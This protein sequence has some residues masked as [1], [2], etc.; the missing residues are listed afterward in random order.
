MPAPGSAGRSPA[1]GASA[2]HP[3]GSG[4]S[5]SPAHEAARERRTDDTAAVAGWRILLLPAVTG[6]LIAATWLNFSLFPLAWVAFVPLLIALDRAADRRT[7]LWVGLVAG[8]ATNVPAFYWLVYTMRVFGGFPLPLAVFFYAC[9]STF[10]AMQF[11]LFAAGFRSLG[12]GSLGLAVPV[13]WVTLEFFFPNLFAWRMGNSQL[14]LPLLMQVGDLTGPY[15]LSFA[16]M[17]VNAGI[18]LALRRR[19][20]EPLLAAGAAVVAVVAY[21]ALR[22]PVVQRAVDAATPVAVGLVQANIGIHEKG[23]VTLFDINLDK[24]RELSR[25]LEP[26]VD[27]LIWPESVAQWWV[28]ADETQL[29]AKHNP[30]VGVQ[31]YLIYGG[32]A[33][34]YPHEGGD[35]LLFNSAFLIDGA[36]QVHG[37]YD[38]QVLIPFGEYIPGGSFFPG[39]YRLSPQTGQFTSGSDAQT[40]DVPDR[41]RVAP[42]ICYEDVPAG[43]ARAMTARGAEALLT[44][45]NDAW[46]GRT[47]APY[48]HEAIA[49]WR[50]IENRRYFVRVGNAGV[51][52]VIDPFGRVVGRLGMFTAETMRA[53]IRPLQLRTFYTAYGDVF[54][55]SVVAVALAWLARAASMRRSD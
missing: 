1:V 51:S 8:L 42:L 23:D 12:F 25:P 44:I 52:S 30:F 33:Y 21:G 24:Y 27:V 22:M 36:G 32:L 50:A 40:L 14:E 2:A 10:S 35:P 54:A 20:W 49:L 38:K 28:A 17:W 18:A 5:A 6:G 45:F 19:R 4:S 31:P 26:R 41:V 46:F 11:V 55:W 7:T 47:M 43:I 53:E 34:Q 15:G 3:S 37:R 29:A 39:L 9:L 48:Q 16:I 13:L